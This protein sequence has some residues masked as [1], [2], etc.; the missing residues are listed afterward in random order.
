MVLFGQSAGSSDTF[1]IAT[2]DEAPKLINSAIMQ[3]GGGRD[4]A[5]VDEAQPWNELFASILGCEPSEVSYQ[6]RCYGTAARQFPR[7]Y[8]DANVLGFLH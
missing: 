1:V 8:A 7:S 6:F 3:S 5:S 4:F 2:L